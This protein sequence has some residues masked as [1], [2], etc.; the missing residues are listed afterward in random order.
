MNIRFQSVILFFALAVASGNN[1]AQDLDSYK[2]KYQDAIDKIAADH[3]Q[4]IES[5]TQIY[6]VGLN[7]LKERV[8]AAGDLNRLKAVL[9]EISRFE[10]NRNFPTEETKLIPEVLALLKEC[11]ARTALA[12]ETK[13]RNIVVLASQFDKALLRLQ[14]ERTRKG[15]LD[16]ATTIQEERKIL[17]ETESLTAAKALLTNAGAPTSVPKSSAAQDGRE[18]TTSKKQNTHLEKGEPVDFSGVWLRYDGGTTTLHT[19]GQVST[20]WSSAKR[21]WRKISEDSIGIINRGREY[22]WT[23]DADADG[24]RCGNDT[25]SRK[26]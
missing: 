4:Q 13:A 17:A 24:L 19:N 3:A 15:E 16:K 14:Q 18:I 11:Q 5:I 25:M 20:D 7:A 6:S 12:E 26:K 23:L 2:K 9:A 21:T 1:H 10:N 22:V 8:Q